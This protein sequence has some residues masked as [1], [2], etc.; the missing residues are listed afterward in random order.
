[1]KGNAMDNNIMEAEELTL[2]NL[3]KYGS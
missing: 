1:M 2:E 3:R